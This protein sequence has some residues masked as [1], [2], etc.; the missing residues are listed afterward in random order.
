MGGKDAGSGTRKRFVTTL[1]MVVLL[2]LVALAGSSVAQDCRRN[3]VNSECNEFGQIHMDDR[4]N[5]EGEPVDV[6]TTITLNTNYEDRDARWIMFSVRNVTADGSSPI[7]IR[8]NSFST[9]EG[10][11]VTTRVVHDDPNE[12]NLWVDVLDLPVDEPIEIDVTVGVTERGAFSV[13]TLVLAFDRGYDPI[14]NSSGKDASL[15][16]YTLLGVNEA[17]DPVSSSSTGSSLG[18]RGVPSLAVAGTVSTLGLAASLARRRQ[19]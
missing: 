10:E 13:E 5:V 16:S 18:I 15:F 2:G 4:K 12:L 6:N 8:L 1:F 3:G 19:R 17:T 7:S 9:D 14:K 11:V